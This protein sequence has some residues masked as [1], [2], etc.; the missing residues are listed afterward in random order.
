MF[1]NDA[2]VLGMCMLEASLIENCCDC[3]L[4]DKGRIN[5]HLLESKL[6][7]LRGYYSDEYCGVIGALLAMDAEERPDFMEVE[8]MLRDAGMQSNIAS[9][10]QSLDQISVPEIIKSSVRSS[11]PNNH[12]T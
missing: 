9:V 7:Q 4:Y 8:E 11:N 5:Q 3:Y 1:K 6:I 10:N 2:F 12:P